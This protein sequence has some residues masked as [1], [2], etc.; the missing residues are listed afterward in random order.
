MN[1]FIDYLRKYIMIIYGFTL[2]VTVIMILFTSNAKS[3]DPLVQ[4]NISKNLSSKKV[5]YFL[6]LIVTQLISFLMNF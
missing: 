1:F 5:I 6:I 3:N 4:K 2:T